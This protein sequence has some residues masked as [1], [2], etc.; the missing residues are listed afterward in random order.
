MPE[1]LGITQYGAVLAPTRPQGGFRVSEA[2]MAEIVIRPMDQIT[3][4]YGEQLAGMT[5]AKAHRVMGRALNY[6]GRRAFIAVKRA[7]RIQTS[8]PVGRLNA[9]MRTNR[10]STTGGALE[11][12]IIGTGKELSLKLFTPRQFKAGVKATVWGKRQTYAGSFMGPRPGVLAAS[13]RGHVFAR[14]S[15]ARSPIKRLSGPSVAKEMVKNES[16]DAFER[17][18]PRVV[19]RVGRE[20]AAVLRGF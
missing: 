12:K 5:T 16:R 4:R 7:M 9:A 15:A 10:A 6:E 13:L 1:K 2:L 11:F 19:D 3:A 18:M 17:A 20:I 14:T 8:I